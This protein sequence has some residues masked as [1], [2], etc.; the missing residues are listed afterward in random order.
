MLVIIILRRALRMRC[1]CTLGCL[2]GR[3]RVP[4]A[5][6]QIGWNGRCLCGAYYN[7][8]DMVPIW[9]PIG[10]LRVP[11][12]FLRVPIAAKPPEDRETIKLSHGIYHSTFSEAKC[13]ECFMYF[14]YFSPNQDR[15]HLLMHCLSFLGYF[16]NWSRQLRALRQHAPTYLLRTAF[17]LVQ[18]KVAWA[19]C[20]ICVPIFNITLLHTHATVTSS[21]SVPAATSYWSSRL[22]LLPAP[23]F[24]SMTDA[25]KHPLVWLSRISTPFGDGMV[26]L[27]QVLACAWEA[28]HPR[29]L[30]L[31]LWQRW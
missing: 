16:F 4:I 31:Q 27:I 15:N 8:H 21:H 7:I 13:L 28:R 25:R 18:E 22:L 5:K 26:K 29:Q 30:N 12:W 2:L 24:F 9:V 3:E 20:G 11:I 6:L 1:L 10:F 14:R 19:C 23:R 17:A